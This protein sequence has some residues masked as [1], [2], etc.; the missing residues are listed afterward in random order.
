MMSALKITLHPSKHSLLYDKMA[1][2]I[3]R[4]I[5]DGIIRSMEYFSQYKSLINLTRVRVRQYDYWIRE[6]IAKEPNGA[7]AYL[8][9]GMD[10]R[11]YRVDPPESIA[12]YDVDFNS[13]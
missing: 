11:V 8:G 1:D 13:F 9:C 2:D 7:V 12:W 10:T 3:I 4:L 6:F 5:D